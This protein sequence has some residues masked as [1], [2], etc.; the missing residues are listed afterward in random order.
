LEITVCDLPC[1]EDGAAVSPKA[2]TEQGVAMLPSV[3]RSKRTIQVNI[4]IMRAFIWLRGMLAGGHKSMCVFTRRVSE[5]CL[6][7]QSNYDI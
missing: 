3:L 7:I 6:R 5:R 1:E 2:F 4:Q